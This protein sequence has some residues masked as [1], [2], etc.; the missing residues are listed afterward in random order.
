MKKPHKHAAL[1]KQWAD[2]AEIQIKNSMGDWDECSP[3][4][5][6]QCDYRV[7]PQPHKWQKE[8]DAHRQGKTI[9]WK[10]LTSDWTT[11]EIPRLHIGE[12][13][14][15]YDA[16]GYSFRI[17]PEPVVHDMSIV[18]KPGEDLTVQWIGYPKNL[19]LT[20]EEGKLVAAEVL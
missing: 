19:R 12:V 10:T 1:I 5:S 20:F 6:T 14:N 7:K 16:P 13:Y 9:Q 11:W 3:S 18:L 17:K 2:G 15:A 8:I 4:W